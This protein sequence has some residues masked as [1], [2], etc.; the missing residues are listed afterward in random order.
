M[1]SSARANQIGA[2]LLDLAPHLADVFLREPKRRSGPVGVPPSSRNDKVKDNQ[3]VPSPIDETDRLPLG[4]NWA[5]VKTS[6]PPNMRGQLAQLLRFAN[7]KVESVDS[8][9]TL[10]DSNYG[11]NLVVT[12]HDRD[13]VPFERVVRMTARGEATI[14]PWRE[15]FKGRRRS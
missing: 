10:D 3:N 4:L 5:E 8:R 14:S 12:V 6:L 2:L 11:W 7:V 1:I 9:R 15:D 13:D